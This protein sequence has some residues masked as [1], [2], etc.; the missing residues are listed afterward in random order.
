MASSLDLTQ[1]QAQYLSATGNFYYI[2]A[3][4]PL[5][6]KSELNRLTSKQQ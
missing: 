3:A 1:A 6:A 2:I 5:N 4:Q